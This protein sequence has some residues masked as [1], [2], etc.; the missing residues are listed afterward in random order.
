MMN[1]K[2]EYNVG[3]CQ[4]FEELADKLLNYG[5]T[6]CTGFEYGGYLFLNDATS[7]D[8]AQEY[9]VIKDGFQIESWTCSW[10]TPDSLLEC[11]KELP[12]S[13]W[14]IKVDVKLDRSGKHRCAFC[15]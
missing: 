2:D 3:T 9:A 11:F 6:L 1:Q 8:G 7:E 12:E 14:R 13:D 4:T 5:W 10:M 15:A